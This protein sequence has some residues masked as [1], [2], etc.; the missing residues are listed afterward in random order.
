MGSLSIDGRGADV[1]PGIA[2]RVADGVGVGLAEIGQHH[3]LPGADSPC[4]RLSDRPWSDEDDDFGHGA[5]L[6][7]RMVT[8]WASGPPSACREVG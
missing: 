6:T 7:R 1:E 4:D 2:H 5:L 3:V 8:G